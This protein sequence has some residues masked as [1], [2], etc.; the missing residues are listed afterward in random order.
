VCYTFTFTTI[1]RPNTLTLMGAEG[2][3]VGVAPYGC[4]GADDMVIRTNGPIANAGADVSVCAGSAA[5]LAAS[6]TG[7]SAPY[8]YLWDNGATTASVSVSPSAT[9][10]YTVAITDNNGNT[11]Y[12]AVTVHVNAAPTANA[13][14]DRN[15]YIGY[16]MS[17]V[18]LT[19]S[20]TSGTSPYT[21]QWN[22]GAQTPV[23]NV[24]PNVSTNYTLTVTDANGCVASDVASVNVEDIRCGSG[25]VYVCRNG[26][27]RCIRTNQ[28]NSYLNSGYTLGACNNKLDDEVMEEEVA[29]LRLYPNPANDAVTIELML[30]ATANVWAEI[31]AMDGRK[32][33]TEDRL[34]TLEEGEVMSFRMATNDL[35]PGIYLVVVTTDTGVRYTERL[36]VAH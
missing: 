31:Y 30:D 7:G 14:P 10:V 28:V 35:K 33:A 32:V 23:I 27:T 34:G 29:A 18:P 11:A 9:A 4:N 25:K 17:C 16:G 15:I 26:R 12:D 1:G 3:G 6:A 8:S 24:C 5:S 36:Q 2:S 19:G 21:Y 22:T 13:G 20:A